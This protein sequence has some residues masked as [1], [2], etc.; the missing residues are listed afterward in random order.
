MQRSK[1]DPSRPDSLKQ[2]RTPKN[3]PAGLFGAG[4]KTLGSTFDRCN[5]RPLSKTSR[6]A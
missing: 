4:I 5:L 6:L 3:K 1:V 2:I